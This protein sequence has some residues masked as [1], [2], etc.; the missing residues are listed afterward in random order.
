MGSIVAEFAVDHADDAILPAC[1]AL[2]PQLA[3][4]DAIV[5]AARAMDGRLLG[6]GGVLWRAW[7]TPA[8]L[9]IW[10]EVLPEHRRRGVGRALLD[11]LATVAT[12]EADRLWSIRPIDEAS[13]AARFA[14]A[15]G[16]TAD[17]R[18]LYFETTNL[19]FLTQMTRIVDRLAAH[20]RVS[21]DFVVEAL[22]ERHLD[23]VKWL[24]FDGLTTTP[25]QLDAMLARA[26]IEPPETAPIDRE[27]SFVLVADGIVAGALLSQRVTDP[28]AANIIC[29]VVDPRWRRGAANALLLQRFSEE[30]VAHGHTHI[31]FDCDEHVRDT[32]GLAKRSEA[33]HLRTES[34][35]AYAIAA[36]MR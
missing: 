33:D 29:N 6:A 24:I 4:P 11:A 3:S 19:D 31:R 12:Q 32:I 16:A 15:C 10:I 20:G 28:P 5:F 1:F 2:L 17:K 21:D 25:P 8:G 18:Q 7:Q 14:G 26:M 13:D 27:R 36:R 34:Y 35:F 9:P 22:A 23:Q 30:T